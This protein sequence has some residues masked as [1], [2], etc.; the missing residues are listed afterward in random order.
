[1]PLY[2]AEFDCE[3]LTPMFLS[4]VDQTTCE[5]RAPSLRGVL[6]YWYRALLGGRGIT[7]L[8][9]L[10]R[11]ETVVFGDTKRGSPLRVRIAGPTFQPHELP[12]IDDHADYQRKS[13]MG[14]LWFSTTLGDNDRRYIPAGT[15]FRVTLS[16]PGRDPE[17]QRRAALL[18]AV[19]AF[20]LTAHLG[21]L[22]SR[23]RRGAG[24]FAAHLVQA[25][26]GLRL[27]PLRP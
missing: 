8:P 22:G 23:A 26:E 3:V 9:D 4:G 25:S 19:D 14:Y 20:W 10:H 12:R 5:L 13:P 11:L 18:E 24:S 6:R 2:K 27:P 17:G 1:M 16:A 15:V 21:A 7:A